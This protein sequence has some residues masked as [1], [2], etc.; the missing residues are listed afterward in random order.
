MCLKSSLRRSTRGLEGYGDRDTD[1]GADEMVGEDG[2][3]EDEEDGDDEGELWG[4]IRRRADRAEGEPA[5]AAAGMSMSSDDAG[6]ESGEVS[7]GGADIGE[8]KVVAMER[9]RPLQAQAVA[10][11]P[12]VPP[13][14]FGGVATAN[15]PP[16]LP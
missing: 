13:Q 9:L 4:A 6:E 7:I 8:S 5:D 15:S 1:E 10:T 14:G 3:E 2:A 11:P 16:S 12:E